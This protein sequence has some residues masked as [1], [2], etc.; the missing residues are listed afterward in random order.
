MM[1]KAVFVVAILVATLITP[2]VRSGAPVR[3]TLI[4]SAGKLN[5][6]ILKI[7][8]DEVT[9]IRDSFGVPHIFAATD[10]G[11]FF[12]GGFAV[13]QDRLFQLERYRR[14][15]RGELAEIE[16]RNAFAHDQEAR[17]L[18]Y[19][20]SELQ[21]IFNSLSEPLRLSYL[22]YADGINA[23]VK[24]AIEN[25]KLAV[26]FTKAGIN[27]PAAWKATDSVA[28]AVMMA[29][30]FGAS[31]GD[32]ILNA[33][34]LKWLKEKFGADADK[35]FN[36][37]FWLND[38]LS[39]LTIPDERNSRRP[40]SAPLTR[41]TKSLP[42]LNLS[43]AADSSLAQAERLSEQAATYEYA[44]E[45]DLPTKWGSYCWAVSPRRSASGSAMLVGGPQMG[46]SIPHIGH[47][48]RYTSGTINVV[49]LGF[50]GI[51]GVVIGHNDNVAWT[52]TTG[53]ADVVDT[54]VE[55]LNPNNQ[56]EYFY[57][58][59]YRSMDKRVEL[60]KIKGEEPKQV[61]I[62]RTAHGPITGW[63]KQAG[64]AYSRAVS[65]WRRE[66]GTI[67]ATYDFNRVKN[68]QEFADV[69]KQVTINQNFCAVT[70]NGDIGYWHCGM[71]PVRAPGH[72][73]R[74]P[75]AGTGEYDWKGFIPASKMPQIINPDQ[76]YLCNWNNKPVYWMDNGDLPVWGEIYHLRRIE[77][78]I[79]SRDK[80]TFEQMRDMN[81]DITTH[82]TNADYLKPYLLSAIDKT[83]AANHDARIREAASY[84]RAWDDRYSDG[85]VAKAIFDAWLQ[86]LQEDIFADEFKELNRLGTILRRIPIFNQYIRPSFI[87][88]SLDGSKSSVPPSRDY[89]NGRSKDEVVVEA[90]K[91]ALDSLSARRGPQMNLWTYSLGEIPFGNLPGIPKADR[92][93]YIFVAEM[94]KPEI[95]SVSILPPGQS[96]DVG[97]PHYADQREMAGSWR[98]KRMG[99][100]RERLEAAYAAENRP[101][102]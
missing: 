11:V 54:F 8:N 27:E 83:G 15:A 65:W 57:N 59:Q 81:S 99:Y 86:N 2:S 101:T 9:I 26:E 67:Q 92:G 87:L 29:Q 53:L 60:I 62:Y 71:L 61:E 82:E 74:L 95:R 21:T 75:V 90:L 20:E 76:G 56:Y 89:L 43:I 77:Q 4:Q 30:R 96:E 10:K 69:A 55:K 68:I 14:D 58:G 73:A 94:S 78:L 64:V 72:D 98:F 42:G 7:E 45:H 100:S 1:G 93:T 50:A 38:P 39:P 91:K 28:I 70:V 24:E 25:K 51:P 19:T 40:S 66:A 36:D 35:V 44:K 37:I 41:K 47:E 23:Y 33:R 13:A 84:L 16:S 5:K 63:D 6:R 80:M 49:G 3:E 88:H 18:G 97:S 46:F 52:I 48:I 12:G 31:G 102:N 32:E 85:S 17:V 22:A 34:I 79:K